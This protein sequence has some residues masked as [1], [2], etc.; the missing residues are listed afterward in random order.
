MIG[1]ALTL[2]L[3]ACPSPLEGEGRKNPSPS[4]GEGGARR[5]AVGG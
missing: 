5:E 3:R 1:T 2:A 4:R